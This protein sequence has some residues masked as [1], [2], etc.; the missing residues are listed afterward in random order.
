[1]FFYRTKEGRDKS[2]SGI[3]RKWLAVP[4]NNQWLGVSCCAINNMT[5]YSLLA[6]ESER[7]CKRFDWMFHEKDWRS[8]RKSENCFGIL[9][10]AFIGRCVLAKR[11]PIRPIST[12]QLQSMSETIGNSESKYL[13]ARKDKIAILERWRERFFRSVLEYIISLTF[14]NFQ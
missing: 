3:W 11:G 9:L 13:S 6:L 2:M 8:F 10:Y 4:I 14:H 5:T 1:M 12:M 7:P